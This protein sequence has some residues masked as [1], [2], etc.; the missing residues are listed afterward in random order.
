MR[1]VEKLLSTKRLLAHV[2]RDYAP[3]A[4]YQSFCAEDIVLAHLIFSDLVHAE[5]RNIHMFAID[6]GR[7]SEQ[8]YRAMES[9]Q[10]RYGNVLTVYH[11]DAS[12][13][14]A[15]DAHF[16]FGTDY[17]QRSYEIRFNK[18]LKR[19]LTGRNAWISTAIDAHTKS[20]ILGQ[21]NTMNRD[22]AWIN[23]DEKHQVPC[24]NPMARWTREEVTNYARHHGLRLLDTT[25][26][27]TPVTT[28][29]IERVDKVVA[30]SRNIRTAAGL[31]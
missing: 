19:A 22:K 20:K 24:F 29:A 28:S 18:P 15:F 7:T 16:G 30:E 9:L 21:L 4:M 6:T 11:P 5:F 12:E 14:A 10:Q 31:G 27:S 8:V 25:E 26:T 17:Y 2:S 3:V 1:A 23:W 13:L